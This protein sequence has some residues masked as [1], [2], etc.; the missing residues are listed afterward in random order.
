MIDN[1]CCGLAYFFP[2]SG[3]PNNS[4]MD[5]KKFNQTVYKLVEDYFN[6]FS[7][8]PHY[9]LVNSQVDL[10]NCIDRE[11]EKQYVDDRFKGLLIVRT[12]DIAPDK[13][14]VY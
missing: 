12:P 4:I 9:L 1:D 8:K 13:L 5:K 6:N 14:A 10:A 2:S 3:H 11:D 7:K